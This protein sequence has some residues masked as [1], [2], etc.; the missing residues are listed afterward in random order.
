VDARTDIYS[1]GCVLYE[2]LAGVIPFQRES[3][4][5]L[6]WAH[7]SESPPRLTDRRPDLPDAVNLVIARAMAKRKEDRYDTCLELMQAAH[8]ALLG[9]T[10]AAAPPAAT[11]CR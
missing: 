4:G 11:P 9:P 3:E 1:L 10:A 7:L 5:S 8:Q 2:C 6:L